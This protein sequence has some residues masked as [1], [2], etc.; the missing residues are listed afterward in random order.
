[1]RLTLTIATRSVLIGLPV[2][3]AVAWLLARTRFPGRPIVDALHALLVDHADRIFAGNIPGRT[4]TLPLAIFTALQTPGGEATAAKLSLVS[5]SLAIAGLLGAQW[6][7]AY[8]N[9]LTGR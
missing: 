5:M 7:A 4:Q 2:A 1:M 6:V 8:L 3:V 9:R